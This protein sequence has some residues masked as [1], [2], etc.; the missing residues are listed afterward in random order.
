[1]RL[2]FYLVLLLLD[3]SAYDVAH[4]LREKNKR[5]IIPAT[6]L[7]S[8]IEVTSYKGWEIYLS[9]WLRIAVEMAWIVVKLTLS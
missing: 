1:L 3:A 5:L 9:T 7:V 2:I 6:A 4:F 8:P